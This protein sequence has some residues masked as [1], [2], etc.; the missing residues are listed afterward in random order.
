[1][2]IKIDNKELKNYTIKKFNLNSS[3]NRHTCVSLE[4]ELLDI[5]Q[6]NGKNI[7]LIDNSNFFYG[8]IYEKLLSRYA[9]EGR[10]AVI[11][12]YSFSKLMDITKNFRIFQDENITY[13]DIATEIMKQYKFKYI[14]S[15]SLKIK[16]QRLYIQYEETDFSFLIRIL[17][18]IKEYIYSTYNG[19][20]VIGV[21]NIAKSNIENVD[22]E[23]EKNGNS[24]YRVKNKIYVVGDNYNNKNICKVDVNLD[25]NIYLTEVEL[26]DKKKYKFIPFNT[27]KGT[28]VEASVVEVIENREVASMKVDF[29]RSLEDKSKNKKILSFSTPYSK[30]N[31]GFFPS[32]EVGD[33][34][35]VYFPSN[36][37]NDAKVAF[38]IN[39]K[40]SN[41]FCNDSY[42]CFNTKEANLELDKG[43]L[44]LNLS[45][46]NL[47]VNK[48]FNC[49]SK[50]YIALE[51]VNESSIYA[52]KIDL[53]SKS[54]DINIKSSNNINLK[55]NKIFNN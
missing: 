41:K 33:I 27:I 44:N 40:G 20:I 12:A 9:R 10:K 47:I 36:N 2:K 30:T 1:M 13:Y 37:E 4:L 53:V 54:E 14:I 39:N 32:P 49:A 42:R 24:Y 31:T 46:C 50:D 16:T 34:V 48:S 3:F 11:K 8:R 5:N 15:D 29:S 6:I 17:Y 51:S 22:I 35:D 21:Q 52:K 38:C 23:G 28:F 43:D 18:N 25:K 7:E 45:K 26:I 55:A 19:V